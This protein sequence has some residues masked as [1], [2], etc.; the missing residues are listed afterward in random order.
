MTLEDLKRANEI[1]HEINECKEN[2]QKAL[3]TQLDEVHC[4]PMS[5]TFNGIEGRLEVPAN[6][7]RVIGKIVLVEHE[8]RLKLLEESLASI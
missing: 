7:F 8:N 4:R 6:L 3:Y 1:A 2:I 5:L